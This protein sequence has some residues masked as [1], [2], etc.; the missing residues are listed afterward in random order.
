MI[1]L[2]LLEED[3][4][5]AFNTDVEDNSRDN[6]PAAVNTIFI[7]FK[8]LRKRRAVEESADTGVNNGER[9]L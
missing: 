5:E 4:T 9:F 1:K 7:V 6:L 3:N 8:I 2:G